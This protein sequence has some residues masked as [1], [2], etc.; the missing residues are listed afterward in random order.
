MKW[1]TTEELRKLI[2]FPEGYRLDRFESEHIP[3]LIAK[4]KVWS[5]GLLLGVNSRFFHEDFYQ[6]FVLAE[7]DVDTDIRVIL[8]TFEDELIGFLA[9]ER[10]LANLAILGR[11]IVIAPNHRGR[12]L[13]LNILRLSE[14]VARFMGAAFI[15]A[16][17]PLNTPYVQQAFE[18]LNYRLSGIFPGY[19][20]DEVSPG[21]VKRVYKSVYTKLLAPPEEVHYPDP[22]NMTPKTRALFELV[23]ADRCT[24]HQ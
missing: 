21:E 8:I 23:F 15:Y 13:L 16:L 12:N 24:E 18:N 5:P 14:S 6:Q 9:I 17:V 1:P 20:F 10:E 22:K 7:N 19:D 3:Q 2:L 4:V 11:Y